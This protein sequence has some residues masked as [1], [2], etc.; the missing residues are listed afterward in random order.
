LGGNIRE[1]LDSQI[2]IENFERYWLGLGDYELSSQEFREIIAEL[3]RAV[4]KFPEH[5]SNGI[6]IYFFSRGDEHFHGIK[7]DFYGSPRVDALLGRAW[8]IFD[9]NDRPVG[10]WDRYDFNSKPWPD[11]S[12]RNHMEVFGVRNASRICISCNPTPFTLTYGIY[13]E[14]IP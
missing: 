2:E 12:L 10:L 9:E 1:Q 4:P 6:G 7:Y 14:S 13:P 11:R 5:I 8:I 3:P